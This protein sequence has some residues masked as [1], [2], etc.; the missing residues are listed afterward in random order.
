[1]PHNLSHISIFFV[2]VVVDEG[3]ENPCISEEEKN[4]ATRT[5][6][7]KVLC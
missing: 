3:K 7:A 4:N 1:M 6:F 2:V 5:K